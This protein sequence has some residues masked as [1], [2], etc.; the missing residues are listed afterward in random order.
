MKF[1]K[2]YIYYTK[3]VI[4]LFTL[5]LTF[6]SCSN[7]HNDGIIFSE[8]MLAIC[9]KQGD[10]AIVALDTVIDCQWDKFYGFVGEYNSNKIIGKKIG[11]ENYFN[12]F[13]FDQLGVRRL[14]FTRQNKIQKYFDLPWVETANYKE[15]KLRVHVYTEE[16]AKKDAIFVVEL[17]YISDIKDEL[18]IISPIDSVG[19]AQWKQ[20]ITSKNSNTKSID[21]YMQPI[22]SFFSPYNS[23]NGFPEDKKK[24]LKKVLW[25]V[26]PDSMAKYDDK[27]K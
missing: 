2:L 21:I 23:F 25:K 17:K 15:L 6:L 8:K 9:Q 13:D 22:N 14:V 11:D 18:N 27:L 3:Q 7:P 16:I 19:K 1:K 4:F 12:F 20:F 26:Y 5:C 24:E 10:I